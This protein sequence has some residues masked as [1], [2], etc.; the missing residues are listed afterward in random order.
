MSVI[1][2]QHKEKTFFLILGLYFTIY[3]YIGILPGNID[4]L[5]T[6]LSGTTQMGIGLVIISRLVSG[7]ISLLVFGYFGEILSNRFGKKRLFVLTNAFSICFNGFIIFSTDYLYFLTL[8]IATSITNGA[9]LPIGFSMVSDLYSPKER[10]KKFGMLQFSL[11]LGNGLGLA[12]GGFLGWRVGFIINCIIGILCLGGYIFYGYEPIHGDSE[13]EFES[14][15]D[16]ANYNFKITISNTKRLL[17]TKSILGI[18]ISVLCY[19]IAISILTNWGIYYL[20]FKL[21]GET[22]AILTHTIIGIG[23]LPAAIIG[24]ELGDIYFR[25]GRPKAR[26]IISFGGLF[27]GILLLLIFYVHPI[28]LLGFF[29]FYFISFANGNQF[30]IYSDVSSPEL[31]GTVNALS[32]IMLNIGGITGN[33]LISTLIQNNFLSLS[34]TLVLFIWLF[35]SFS[36]LIPYFYYSKESRHRNLIMIRRRKELEVGSFNS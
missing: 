2:D 36:W 31:R 7:T 33:L 4:N 13:P 5:I 26:V 11:V 8:S 20:T 12:L 1:K 18:F 21:G 3:F 30:A 28:L 23:A 34:I 25:S 24:G 6:D 32:G 9:F 14:F 16:A 15:K 29:G 22:E 27:V 17:K 35:G 19:G 10:G